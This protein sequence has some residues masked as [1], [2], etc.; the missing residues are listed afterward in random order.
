M[1]H[2]NS[3]TLQGDFVNQAWKNVPRWYNAYGPDTEKEGQFLPKL[4]PFE[5]D[6][7]ATVDNAVRAAEY[8]SRLHGV[9]S[10]LGPTWYDVNYHNKDEQPVGWLGDKGLSLEPEPELSWWQDMVK[11]YE[12]YKKQ[13]LIDDPN[14]GRFPGRGNY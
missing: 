6:S 3:V 9:P 13:R 8:R 7:Y 2:E 12:A 4:H 14:Q 11:R 10:N 5:Q 1:A